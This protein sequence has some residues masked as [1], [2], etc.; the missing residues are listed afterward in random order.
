MIPARGSVLTH[1]QAREL[2]A[3]DLGQ[4]LSERN[5]KEG[6]TS[7]I[8]HLPLDKETKV[9]KNKREQSLPTAINDDK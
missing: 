3:L 7:S 8:P 4:Q 9:V 6:A 2:D 1:A 5:Q